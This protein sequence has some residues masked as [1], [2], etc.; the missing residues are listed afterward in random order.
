MTNKEAKL[1]AQRLCVAILY[2]TNIDFEDYNQKDESKIC[3]YIR[4]EAEKIYK[5]AAKTGGDFNRFDATA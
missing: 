4:D 3:D 5:K 2:N 1:E